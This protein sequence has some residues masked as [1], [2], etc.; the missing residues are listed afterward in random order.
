MIAAEFMGG[1]YIADV[2]ERCEISEIPRTVVREQSDWKMQR[3]FTP[4]PAR[5]FVD[6]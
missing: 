1:L 3:S 6:L 2:H 5:W 4:G